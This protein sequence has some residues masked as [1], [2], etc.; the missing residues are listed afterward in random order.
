MA[1]FYFSWEQAHWAT[2]DFSFCHSTSMD[3]YKSSASVDLGVT[4][5]SE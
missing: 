2:Q 3:D 4:D 5:F 1:L